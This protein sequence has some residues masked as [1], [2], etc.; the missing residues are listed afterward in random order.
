MI[1]QLAIFAV[2][3][4]IIVLLCEAFNAPAPTQEQIEARER[5]LA[6]FRDLPYRAGRFI[7]RLTR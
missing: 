5:L 6:P 3:A 2:G 7:R 1:E 4:V